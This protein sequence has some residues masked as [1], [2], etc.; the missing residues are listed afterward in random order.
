MKAPKYIQSLAIAS[1]VEDAKKYH[2]ITE[3]D[4]AWIN[5]DI[6]ELMDIKR[7]LLDGRLYLGVESVSKSGMS[8][9]IKIRYIKN[10]RLYGCSDLIYELAGCDKNNRI[11]GCG[12][13][14]LFAAQY[15][16]FMVL[17]PNHR[18]QESMKRYNEL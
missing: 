15:D 3:G 6:K 17:C 10:N 8:R 4:Q 1:N 12:M 13:D 9:I 14:M 5:S 18:Y 16:L 7:A 11:S 2:F